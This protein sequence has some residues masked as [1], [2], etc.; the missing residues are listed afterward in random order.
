M[1]NNQQPTKYTRYIDIKQFVIQDLVNRDI[2]FFKRISTSESY[3]DIL[4]KNYGRTLHYNIFDYVMIRIH[5]TY[6]DM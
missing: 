6:T 5:L 1:A 4:T 2:L 3:S